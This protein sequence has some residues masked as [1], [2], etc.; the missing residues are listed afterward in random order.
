MT[1]NLFRRHSR[2]WQN[3]CQKRKI[4]SLFFYLYALLNM[5]LVFFVQRH[6]FKIRQTTPLSPVQALSL[7]G[8]AIFWPHSAS[9]REAFGQ[10]TIV[11]TI[12]CVGVAAPIEWTNDSFFGN[13]SPCLRDKKHRTSCWH[14]FERL[15]F[16]SLSPFLT[17]ADH[18]LRSRALNGHF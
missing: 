15:P 1:A 10:R 11:Q 13:G 3:S 4:Q 16:G 17:K 2:W 8:L 18:T 5:N 7:E 9:S 6:R 14:S 12:M